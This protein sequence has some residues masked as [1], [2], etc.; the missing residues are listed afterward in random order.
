MATAR[1]RSTKKKVEQM[2]VEDTGVSEVTRTYLLERK[3][4]KHV[5]ITIPAGWYMTFGPLTPGTSRQHW[6]RDEPGFLALRVYEAKD[7]Q[8]AVFTDI[9]SFRDTS[10]LVE[11]LHIDVD[12]S[13]N[14]KIRSNG[15]ELEVEEKRGETWQRI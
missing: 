2:A 7:K 8:R 3:N 1:K 12:R 9:R 10:I 14:E 4:G 11:E 13:K 5:R 6:G 15:F